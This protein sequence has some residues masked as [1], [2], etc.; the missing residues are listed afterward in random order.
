DWKMF[1]DVTVTEDWDDDIR[2]RRE[3]TAAVK[4]QST[5]AQFV[6]SVV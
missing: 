1:N 3:K 4:E 5:L 6:F 2:E